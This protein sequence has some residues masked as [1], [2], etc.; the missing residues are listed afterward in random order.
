MTHERILQEAAFLVRC[1]TDKQDYDRHIQDLA[2]VAER[3]D[4]HVSESN[5]FGEY[6]TGKDDTT[7]QDRLS[8]RWCRNAAEATRQT[9]DEGGWYHTGDLGVMD[10]EKILYMNAEVWIRK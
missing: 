9:L 5:I 8:V 10:K 4:L 7:E 3:F 2:A 1:S 6:I